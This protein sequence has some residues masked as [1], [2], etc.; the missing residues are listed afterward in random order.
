MR[1]SILTSPSLSWSSP[2]QVGCWQ[3]QTPGNRSGPRSETETVR[4]WRYPS[5]WEAHKHIHTLGIVLGTREVRNCQVLPQVWIDFPS[6]QLPFPWIFRSSRVYF[7]HQRGG[8]S[9]ERWSVITQSRIE[10]ERALPLIL[11]GEREWFNFEVTIWVILSLAVVTCLISVSIGKMEQL[12]FHE[13]ERWRLFHQ[14]LAR[15]E[16]YHSKNC[17]QP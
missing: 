5:T 15:D 10:M 13:V 3:I 16:F 6:R 12:G 9:D 7:R 1:S 2:F 11:S 8:S 14:Y 17:P 4:K